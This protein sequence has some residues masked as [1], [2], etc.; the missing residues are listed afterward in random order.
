M[1]WVIEG[2]IGL[3]LLDFEGLPGAFIDLFF[4][5]DSLVERRNI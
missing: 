1:G 3:G 2:F 4:V 5:Q